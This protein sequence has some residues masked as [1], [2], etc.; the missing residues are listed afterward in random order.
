MNRKS[1]RRSHRD[2]RAT[3]EE[4]WEGLRF[5]VGHLIRHSREVC[6]V[7][8]EWSYQPA[9]YYRMGLYDTTSPAKP[10]R[11]HQSKPNKKENY[12]VNKKGPRHGH[13]AAQSTMKEFREGLG[14][15]EV[16]FISHF[17]ELR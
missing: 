13:R 10:G 4:L 14:S 3:M 6:S 2:A 5:A 7:R 15:A 1:S 9:A 16:H 11:R 17:G 12:T 8:R